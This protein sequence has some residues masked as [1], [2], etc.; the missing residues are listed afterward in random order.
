MLAA[1]KAKDKK[2]KVKSIN[3][4]KGLNSA[5]ARRVEELQK[6]LDQI[7]GRVRELIK[8]RKE[9]RIVGDR[10]VFQSEVLFSLG[11][12]ELGA[13]GK[14]EMKK[15]ATTLMDIEKSLPNDIDWILQIEGH[16]DSLPVKKGQS[17]AD[18]WELSTKSIICSQIFKKKVLI[19]KNYLHQVLA[20]INQSTLKIQKKH[21]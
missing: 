2:E 21:E 10:F 13:K 6:N 20:V 12:D 17:Y 16:T 11:S 8:G 1:Y 18:N 5:L 19:L 7:F 14:I 9:I 4:G 3:L 15:L